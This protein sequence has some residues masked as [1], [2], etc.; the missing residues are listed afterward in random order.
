[1]TKL[2]FITDL[3]DPHIWWNTFVVQMDAENSAVPK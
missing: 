2:N 3:N 1:M